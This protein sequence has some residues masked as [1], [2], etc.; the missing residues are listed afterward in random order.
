[1]GGIPLEIAGLLVILVLIVIGCLLGA[2]SSTSLT[3]QLA[4]KE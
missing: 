3:V 4:E 2:R 1:M